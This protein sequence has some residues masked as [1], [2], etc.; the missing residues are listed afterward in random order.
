MWRVIMSMFKVYMK[1]ES[2]DAQDAFMRNVNHIYEGIE[3]VSMEYVPKGEVILPDDKTDG[4][5]K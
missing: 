1:F 2:L 4:D 3:L 5:D